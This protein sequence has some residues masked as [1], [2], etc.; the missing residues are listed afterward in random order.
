M[1]VGNFS[2]FTVNINCS[3]SLVQ[4]VIKNS[5]NFKT[6]IISGHKFEIQYLHC[7]NKTDILNRSMV[8]KFKAI[9]YT[10]FKLYPFFFF[11]LINTESSQLSLGFSLVP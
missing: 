1:F 2:L 8:S 6:K 11:Y 3:Y 7:L 5:L 9:W 4:W 10:V